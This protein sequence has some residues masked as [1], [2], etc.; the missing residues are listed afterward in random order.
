MIGNKGFQTLDKH[1]NW[2][3]GKIV[4]KCKCGN[5]IN[6]HKCRI[7]KYCSRECYLKYYISP[8]KGKKL[9]DEHKNKL[10]LAKIGKASKK[11]GMRFD[12][13]SGENHWNWKGG[14]FINNQGYVI[15]RNRYHPNAD[16]NGN[17]S[18]HRL[19]MEKK[20]G[21]LLDKTEVVHHINEDKRDNRI[22]N[23]MLFKN[24]KAHNEYH[25]KMRNK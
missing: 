12:N 4:S 21:R 14:R 1:W 24:R 16:K 18:E 5:I 8:G 10:S 3:G 19:E 25:K 17:V 20:I 11:K 9:S 6:S 2:N 22:E 7:K 15:I 13:L 23:L